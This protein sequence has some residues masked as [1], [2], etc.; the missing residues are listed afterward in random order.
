MKVPLMYSGPLSLRIASGLPRYD[1]LSTVGDVS[2]DI[3]VDSY[4]I[5]RI[6]LKI[7][8]NVQ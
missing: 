1:F 2:G 4:G 5:S 7:E 3:T 6:N 8:G